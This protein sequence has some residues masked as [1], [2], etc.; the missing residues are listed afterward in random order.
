MIVNQLDT[1]DW[2][3]YKITNP[4]GRVYIGKT[5]NWYGRHNNYKNY[6]TCHQVSKQRMLYHSLC[7]YGFEDHKVEVIDTFHSDSKY[8]SGK[9]MFWIKSYMC[10]IYKFPEQNGLNLTDGGEGNLG[11][12]RPEE[13]RL[14]IIRKNTGKKNL[15]NQE[16]NS[17][18]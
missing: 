17:S 11:W 14:E 9:E 10:N 7:K 8:C 5:S 13:S 16:K 12:K 15:K 1:R 4:S 3:I 2:V 6:K 18:W